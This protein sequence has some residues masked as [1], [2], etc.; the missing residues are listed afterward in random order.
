MRRI[1]VP[2]LASLFVLTAFACG[3]GDPAITA[4]SVNPSTVA[5]GGE[6]TLTVTI[7]NFN[8]VNPDDHGGGHGLRAAQHDHGDEAAAEGEYP[9][10]GH[11]HVYLNSVEENP[12]LVNCPDHCK[13][14]AFAESVRLSIPETTDAGQHTIIARLNDNSHAILTPHIMATVGLTVE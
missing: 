8:L 6:V 11:F 10:E 1:C 14:S 13:H 7:E 5:P 3:E 9:D 2:T 12:V 4:I